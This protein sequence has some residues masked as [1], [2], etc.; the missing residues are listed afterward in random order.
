M[1]EINDEAQKSNGLIC[2]SNQSADPSVPGSMHE[3]YKEV[4]SLEISM[5][6]VKISSMSA[7][8]D[9]S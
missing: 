6:G 8:I 7:Q 9:S 4:Q 2:A 3:I 1:L 5:F